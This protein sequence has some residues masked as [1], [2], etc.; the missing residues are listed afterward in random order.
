MKK[1][2]IIFLLVLSLSACGSAE[3]PTALET[4]ATT[5]PEATVQPEAAAADG[6]D[7]LGGFWKV[8][9]I[10]NNSRIIDIEDVPSWRTST[11]RFTWTSGKT[12]PLPTSTYGF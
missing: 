11:I 4:S 5:I 7:V 2:A 10:Y 1:L 3:Q 9:A 8:E 12:A 6:F